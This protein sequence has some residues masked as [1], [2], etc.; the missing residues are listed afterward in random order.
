MGHGL[1]G[2]QNQSS[3]PLNWGCGFR[4]QSP[5]TPGRFPGASWMSGSSTA[6]WGGRKSLSYEDKDQSG[7][8]H[9]FRAAFYFP[10]R[11]RGRF[12]TANT[13]QSPARKKWNPLN[14]QSCM[15]YPPSCLHTHRSLLWSS[16]QCGFNRESM[17][18]WPV[19]QHTE[20]VGERGRWRWNQRP[21]SH[22]TVYRPPIPGKFT[23]RQSTPMLSP[24]G[25]SERQEISPDKH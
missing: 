13:I 1:L 19:W 18:S 23:W 3:A 24:K 15:L 16:Q 2:G 6:H 7:S 4:A 8:P 5:P 10:L 12:W 11:W 14:L 25:L 9:S 17:G 20:L 21:P 22:R